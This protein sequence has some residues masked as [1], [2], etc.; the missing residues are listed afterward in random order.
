LIANESAARATS[1][2]SDGRTGPPQTWGDVRA[3]AGV[4]PVPR[5]PGERLAAALGLPF[6]PVVVKTRETK[7]QTEL[8]VL[9]K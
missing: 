8:L 3:V 4:S 5:V 6:R 7:P 1:A 9:A 2:G